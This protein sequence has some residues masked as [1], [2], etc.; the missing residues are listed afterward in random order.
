MRIVTARI[1]EMFLYS[2]TRID[3]FNDAISSVV[4]KYLKRLRMVPAK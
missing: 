3:L 2:F 1:F 4:E